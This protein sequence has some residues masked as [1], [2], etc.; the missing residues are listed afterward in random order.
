[1]IKKNVYTNIHLM[2]F[3]NIQ[4]ENTWIL[5][6]MKMDTGKKCSVMNILT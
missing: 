1:M 4:R 2:F 6:K 3:L 5:V